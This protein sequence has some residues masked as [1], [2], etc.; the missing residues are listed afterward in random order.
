MSPPQASQRSLH[1]WDKT[2]EAYF[3]D[4]QLVG[5]IPVT[6]ADIDELGVHLRALLRRSDVNEIKEQFARHRYTWMTYMAAVAARNDDLGYWDALGQTLGVTGAELQRAGLGNAFLTT[7][8]ALGL[9]HFAE[10]GGYRYVTPIRLHGGIP[11]Y[12]LPDFFEHILLPAAQVPEYADMAVDEII[13][14]MLARSTVQLWVDS[15]ARYYL[16]YGGVPAQ[17]FFQACLKMVQLWQSKGDLPAAHT[18]GL[19]IYVVRA[20]RI[21]MENQTENKGQ[22][23]LRAPRLLLDPY[24]ATEL[25]RL[26]LPSEPVAGDRAAWQHYWTITVIE[27]GDHQQPLIERVR[28]RRIGYDQVTDGR[29]LPLDTAPANIRVELWV[30]PP[31]EEKATAEQLGR[32]ILNLIP[33]EEPP[34]LA[35]RPPNGQA[36]RWGEALPGDLLWLLYPRDVQIQVHGVERRVQVFP[37]LLG[38]WS[39]WQIAAWDLSKADSLTLYQPNQSKR[40]SPI[41][42]RGRT[43][44]PRFEGG[45]QCRII[46]IT[47]ET[48]FYVG[49][50]PWLWL[51]RLPSS[52]GTKELETWSITIIS[53]W[54]AS[55]TLLN[56]EPRP[57]T[58]WQQHLVTDQD[59]IR[60]PIV[61]LLGTEPVGAYTITVDGSHRQHTELRFRIWP[62][63]EVA[64][65]KPYYLPGPAGAQPVELAVY[66]GA[67]H[68]VTVQPGVEG[69]TVAPGPASGH[70]QI[71]VAPEATE[72]PIFLE[73]ARSGNEPI[74]V[75]VHLAVARLRWMLRLDAGDT[76][77]STTP[78]QCPVDALLQSVV[79]R[80]VLE[81]AT[82]QWPLCRLVLI[83]V[84][85]TTQP[86]QETTTL[87]VHSGQQ[88]IHLPLHEFADTLRHHQDCAIFMVALAVDDV[89][90][91]LLYLNRQL[92]IE[93]ALLEWTAAGQV[94]LHWEAQHYL[95][96]RR[97]CFWSTWQPWLEPLEFIIP[98]NPETSD[99]TNAPGSGVF[100]L[101]E[102][103]PHGWYH[104]ALRTAPAWEPLQ[105]PTPPPTERILLRDVDPLSRLMALKELAKASQ[106]ALFDIHFECACIFETLNDLGQRNTEIQ[107]LCSH[108]HG[109]VPQ[110]ILA[111]YHWLCVRDTDMSKAVRLRMYAPEHLTSILSN[112]TPEKLH[113]AYL[114]YFTKITLIKPE[115]A[116]L[117]LRYTQRPDLVSHALRVLV[118]RNRPE[119]V[120]F[121][122]EQVLAG[123]Y[124]ERD[125][126]TLLSADANFGLQTLACQPQSPVRDRLIDALLMQIAPSLFVKV[127]FWVHTEAGWGRIQKIHRDGQEAP[128]FA[129]QHQTPIL[130]VILRPGHQPEYIFIDLAKGTITFPRVAQVYVCTKEGCTGFASQN[131]EQVL[132]DH[133]RAAHLGIGPAFRSQSGSWRYQ[134][135]PEYS[136][137]P[138][139]N[140]FA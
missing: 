7:A 128:H 95:R 54:A 40:W 5:E 35:F 140:V 110:H 78:I 18:L 3:S 49:E 79:A 134:R 86:L 77:W 70:Y 98:D 24:S 85:D 81:L 37:E 62:N 126:V 68:R 38:D 30:E 28:V 100:T 93:V 29:I 91:P 132:Y 53:R 39:G 4:I 135:Q 10:A 34:L 2:L 12:S 6:P 137:Q 26:E 117:V 116:L 55:P 41:A 115:S 64:G 72:A 99:L 75:A 114:E 96:N 32:W 58:T 31:E 84:A 129:L 138:P 107:W 22:L 44:A 45:N 101:P 71:T 83:N 119:A 61:A 9:S 59:G 57:L 133:N 112:N 104:I 121:L 74:R 87:A 43:Q 56:A 48:P 92:T 108:L 42:V 106:N 8:R 65:W 103:L 67:A 63:L 102:T 52:S 105:P 21:F 51:P 113:Q 124:R 109:S 73:A 46:R 125:V 60:L 118:K 90:L 47:D 76:E 33:N 139:K 94:R 66:V 97:V 130:E 16:T 120:Q 23:R 82:E 15:P 14:S 88:R 131:Q 111:F 127:G 80:L 11:A 123:A 19:P 36:V 1:H 13:V 20:F 136:A 25:Y 89:Y 50:P 27:A 122:L 69:I 17:H